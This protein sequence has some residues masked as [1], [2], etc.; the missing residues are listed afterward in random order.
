MSWLD[1]VPS[2]AKLI[3]VHPN[4]PDAR[5]LI[6][7]L[8]NI[9]RSHRVALTDRQLARP[10]VEAQIKASL[11][12]T[13]VDRWQDLSYLVIEEFER[14]AHNSVTSVL[15]RLTCSPHTRIIIITREIPL[16]KIPEP[17]H[18]AT[19]FYPTSDNSMMIDYLHAINDNYLEIFALN[20]IRITWNGVEMYPRRLRDMEYRIFLRIAHDPQG[21]TNQQLAEDLWS[22]DKTDDDTKSN[23]RIST[24]I[25]NIRKKFRRYVQGDADIIN[26]NQGKYHLNRQIT[27]VSDIALFQRLAERADC[28][29][30]RRAERLYR[31]DYLHKIADAWTHTTRAML[32]QLC[33]HVLHRLSQCTD[34]DGQ[35]GKYLERAFEL[36]SLDQAIVYDRIKYDYEHFRP[37]TA[38]SVYFRFVGALQAANPG[39]SIRPLID[40][41]LLVLIKK[42]DGH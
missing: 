3:I 24:M 40:K 42:I 39:I 26:R 28:E 37:D 33:A 4:Y 25:G 7:D 16:A 27:L 32:R 23:D 17:L 15:K 29:M 9:E 34:V 35:I 38:L 11:R 6:A 21:V 5:L 14:V 18:E 13:S 12:D 8:I 19:S 20:D 41:N 30:L 31:R 10:A 36:N 22:T 2:D 1:H